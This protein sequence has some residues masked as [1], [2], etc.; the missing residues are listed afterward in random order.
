MIQPHPGGAN[1][2]LHSFMYHE[3]AMTEGCASPNPTAM[4]RKIQSPYYNIVILL[5]K[6][7]TII[8]ILIQTSLQSTEQATFFKEKSRKRGVRFR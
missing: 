4:L 6:I 7:L 2:L 8:A 3:R 1:T 5:K